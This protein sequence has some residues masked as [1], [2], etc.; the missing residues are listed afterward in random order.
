MSAIPGTP[1]VEPDQGRAPVTATLTL[2][3]VAD[4][5]GVTRGSIRMH[6]ARSLAN[7]R[8]GIFRDSDLPPA[9]G[10][11][12]RTLMWEPET[13]AAWNTARPRWGKLKGGDDE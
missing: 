8:S 5:S 10:R 1:W 2:D 12:G 7:R 6:R 3:D 13:I 11:I 4:V 9:A